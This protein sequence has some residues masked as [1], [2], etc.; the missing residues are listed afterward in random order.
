[1]QRHDLVYLQPHESYGF[2]NASLPLSVTTAV[3]KM[4]ESQQPLTACRQDINSVIKVATSYIED[5]R[6]YRLALNLSKTPEV[7]TSPLALEALISQLPQAIREHTQKFIERCSHL[8]CDVRV[9]GSFANQYFTGLPFVKPTSDLDILIVAHS[10][11]ISQILL[12]MEAFNLL[13]KS[14]VGLK[15][16]GE[17]R[18]HGCNDISFNELIY[19]IMFDIPTVLVK[20]LCDIKLQKIDVLLGWN[21]DEFEHFIRSN[22]QTFIAHTGSLAAD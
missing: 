5:G 22:K 11:N 12:E 18:L 13:A 2:M 8:G 3:G 19:A 6:K 1:M 10:N 17:I 16:D 7:I 14:A 15:I 4:I 20:T 21:T 9:Y